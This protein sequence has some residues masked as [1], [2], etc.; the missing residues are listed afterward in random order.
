LNLKE[1]ASKGEAMG[2]SELGTRPVKVAASS[3]SPSSAS[4]RADS[5]SPD[6]SGHADFGGYSDR[7]GKENWQK[8]DERLF[9][10]LSCLSRKELARVRI[11]GCVSSSMLVAS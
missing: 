4:L 5:T 6:S 1:A 7:N 10:V 9:W 2:S 8:S 3:R 11:L